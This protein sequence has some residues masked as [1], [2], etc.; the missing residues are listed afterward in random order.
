[1]D[2]KCPSSGEHEKMKF[3][4]FKYLVSLGLD[5]IE[6]HPAFMADWDYSKGKAFL[7]Q[8]KKVIDYDRNN[9]GRLISKEYSKPLKKSIDLVIQPDGDILPNWTYLTFSPA[10]RK[11]FFILHLSEKDI[12]VFK[13]NLVNYLKKLDEFF[14][15]GR[16]YRDFS[17]FNASLI[18]GK[19][20]DEKTNERFKVYEDIC[21]GAQSI[22]RLPMN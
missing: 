13:S 6:V 9:K 5:S 22:D 15:K 19:K 21:M 12:K 10:L 2:V 16:S 7:Q 11:E 17:N 4:N 14:K 20:D 1:M 18:L 8:Y 3:E